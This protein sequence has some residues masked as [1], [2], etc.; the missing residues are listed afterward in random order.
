MAGNNSDSSEYDDD[1]LPASQS[2]TAMYETIKESY[3]NL[4]KDTFKQE[5]STRFSEDDLATYRT[6]LFVVAREKFPETQEG[7]LVN[8][9]DTS[10]SGGSTAVNKL[11]EDIYLIFQY[12][13]GDKSYDLTKMFSE[14]S[15]ARL[16]EQGNR[17]VV[18]NLRVQNE[19][20]DPE[21]STTDKSMQE[22][23]IELLQEMRRDR[24]LIRN[25]LSEV[26]KN[27]AQLSLIRD[28]VSKMNQRLVTLETKWAQSEKSTNDVKRNNHAAQID[29]MQHR[30]DA[31][32]KESR[33]LREMYAE[34][35]DRINRLDISISRLTGKAATTDEQGYK[36][37]MLTAKMDSLSTHV[38]L[39]TVGIS[40]PRDTSTRTRIEKPALQTLDVRPRE[41]SHVSF[42]DQP[43]TDWINMVTSHHDVSNR[44][45]EQHIAGTRGN[46]ASNNVDHSLVNRNRMDNTLPDNTVT[47]DNVPKVDKTS[48]D[49]LV[50]QLTDG[51]NRK[52]IYKPQTQDGDDELTGFIPVRGKPRYSP[53]FVS[54]IM[55]INESVEDTVKSVETYM[56]KR[57]CTFKWV[58][59]VRDN[60]YT[61]SV[62]ILV[63]QKEMDKMLDSG[64][65]PKGIYCRE[66]KN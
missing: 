36:L 6:G 40:P 20:R 62:K 38:G 52:T 42:I 7:I 63:E 19:H 45:P 28:D 26:K 57:D 54:G 56:E 33:A 47:R 23:C 41:T 59:K 29:D 46:T 22:F 9:K 58:R 65:W 43:K 55:I 24:D 21:K 32:M 13:E 44:P 17:R 39:R 30:V 11:A 66:W 51:A 8:R 10:Q 37:A 27:T 18:D 2:Q 14:K 49:T 5:M 60:G 4:P 3:G 61:V 1:L 64:F 15:K 16:R 34:N 31:Q 35:V 50:M 12:I 48:D 53:I 25:E